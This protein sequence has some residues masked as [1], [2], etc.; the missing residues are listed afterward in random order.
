[1]T[2]AEDLS[3]LGLSRNDGE[4]SDSRRRIRKAYLQLSR[5]C[6]PDKGGS[7][8]SFQD[9]NAAYERLTRN[10]GQPE[11]TPD[12]K[13]DFSREGSEPERGYNW[14]DDYYAFFRDYGFYNDKKEY[15]DNFAMWEQ[16]REQRRKAYS[17]FHRQQ[18]KLGRDY[19]TNGSKKSQAALCMFCGVNIAITEKKAKQNG[20][21]WDE[22][23][24]ST[25]VDGYPGYNTCWA[26][27]DSHKSVLTKKMACKKFAKVLD[28]TIS[29]SRTGREYH[30][31]F[32]FLK[33]AKRT[34]HHQPKTNMTDGPTVNSEYYWYPDLEREALARGWQPRGQMKNSVP[35]SRKDVPKISRATVTPASAP[36]KRQREGDIGD[37]RKPR[38]KRRLF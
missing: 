38:A 15:E 1:M 36:T 17:E 26:C 6:H 16:A 2:R 20:V 3:T 7:K 33:L 12:N 5:S 35:W 22:Y 29:S 30:P 34:F 4:A 19:D 31:V 9:I 25:N 37:E 21:D 8:E 23:L 13:E 18:V 27:K 14:Y 24:A 28:Y 11:P 32:W 10:E